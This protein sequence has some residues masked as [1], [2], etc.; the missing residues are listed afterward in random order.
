MIKATKIL[1]ICTLAALFSLGSCVREPLDV[2]GRDGEVMMTL[3]VTVPAA[4]MPQ[5]RAITSTDEQFLQEVKVIAFDADGGIAGTNEYLY[6]RD[7]AVGSVVPHPDNGG[8]T[9]KITFPAPLRATN[10]NFVVIANANT[11][12]MTVLAGATEGLTS[13]TAILEDSRLIKTLSGTDVWNAASSSSFSPIPMHGETAATPITQA[14]TLAVDLTRMLARININAETIPTSTFQMSSVRLY[15]TNRGGYIAPGKTPEVTWAFMHVNGSNDHLTYALSGSDLTNNVLLN[16]IYTFER[17]SV[18][19]SSPV[20]L[21]VGGEFN[22]SPTETYYKIIL[23]EAPSDYKSLVRNNSYN[24]TISSV[25]GAGH[26]TPEEAYN[27]TNVTMTTNIVEWQGYY[28]VVVSD[29]TYTMGVNEGIIDLSYA[30]HN[31]ASLDNKLIIRTDY[32]TGWTAVVSGSLS[33]ITAA[34]WLTLS[35][36]SGS[37]SGSGNTISLNMPKNTSGIRTAYVH[38]TA[39]KMT[40]KVKVVQNPHVLEFTTTPVLQ[41]AHY[42]MYP[43]KFRN[44]D[45]GTYNW[46]LSVN[47]GADA[48]VT[49]KKDA[50]RTDLQKAGY[51]T[52]YIRPDGGGANRPIIGSGSISGTVTGTAEQ[53]VYLFIRENLS[54][55]RPVTLSLAEQGAGTTTLVVSQLGA[56]WNSGFYSERLEDY[57]SAYTTGYPWGFNWDKK[58]TF[59]HSGFIGQLLAWYYWGVASDRGA[60]TNSSSPIY[61]SGA[62]GI[63]SFNLIIDYGKLNTPGATDM[64]NGLTNTGK[65]WGTNAAVG[66]AQMIAI[67]SW[68][69]GRMFIGNP[70]TTGTSSGNPD[71]Y[72]ARMCVL[73]NNF[74]EQEIPAEN[75]EPI[76]Y[77]LELASIKWYLPAINQY[78][79][80]NDVAYPL[81]PRDYWSSTEVPGG[82]TTT[83]YYNNGSTSTAQRALNKYIRCTR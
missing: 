39:G 83:Y 69:R 55:E 1:R 34:A 25:T 14:T 76:S 47:A 65:L 77:I 44:P 61:W 78:S 48:W 50:D 71:Y 37:G 26:A 62:T 63:G 8:G 59:P 15:N 73:K 46:T 82:G 58:I 43:V 49:L 33:N 9:A 10:V 41:D 22:G 27:S 75:S 6:F 52:E 32:P 51:W 31:A 79:G 72:A 36:A 20:V 7:G 80:I 64:N 30:Q 70:T 81:L 42:V 56:N 67:E 11:E 66:T 29:G 12:L 54:A 5:S 74:Y 45:G 16:T 28:P 40:Y 17:P 3:T 18:T 4:V 2:I 21:V 53:T 23:M 24:V 38:I 60:T 68:A 19:S 13:K 35:G 57:V